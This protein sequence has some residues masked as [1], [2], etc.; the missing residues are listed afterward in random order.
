MKKN[1]YLLELGTQLRKSRVEDA[2]EIVSE[3]EQHFMFK[4]TEGY[5]EEEIAAK[6][7]PPQLVARHYAD[8]SE[9]KTPSAGMGIKIAMGAMAVLEVIIYL[10]FFAWV[11]VMAAVTIVLAVLGVCLIFKVSVSGLIPP[12]P[13]VSSLILGIST[14]SLALLFT[15][16]TQL[17]FAFLT[18][19][20]RASIRWHGIKTGKSALP[21]LSWTPQ[22][23]PARHRRNRNLLL[24][25]LIVF[26]VTFVLAFIVS[27][28]LAGSIE[29]WHVWGWFG[30][31]G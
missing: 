1:D 29:F 13:Y 26:G 8:V 6:L 31:A 3:Y 18:Q 10:M 20:I 9:G 7:E 28:L 4:L 25:G 12:M 19:V 21:P 23:S 15:S 2:D 5:T 27:A 24:V 14:L 22:L 11:V 30:S 16:L 17:C